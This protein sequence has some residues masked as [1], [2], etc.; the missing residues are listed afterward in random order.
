MEFLH[1]VTKRGSPAIVPEGLDQALGIS[2][3]CRRPSL[4]LGW[5][6]RRLETTARGMEEQ[7]DPVGQ[8]DSKIEQNDSI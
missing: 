5:M 8:A 1:S 4:S 2:E 7:L 3:T 6:R